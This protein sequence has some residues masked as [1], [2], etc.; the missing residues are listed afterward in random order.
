V[1]ARSRQAAQLAYFLEQRAG[2]HRVE[3]VWMGAGTDRAY[4]G[5]Q[6]QWIDGP[7]PQEMRG[8]VAQLADQA[9][10]LGTADLRY[11]RGRTD[12]AEAAALL[13]Y[14]DD[15]PDEAMDAN[16][17]TVDAAFTATSYPE[18]SLD[19]WPQRARALLS[20]SQHASL[21]TGD[22]LPAL[23][24]RI[25]ADGWNG[26]I[27]WLDAIAASADDP[28]EAGRIEE[29]GRTSLLAGTDE[30]PGRFG[31]LVLAVRSCMRRIRR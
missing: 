19:P 14:L 2:L 10:A 20:L 31:R 17:F 3:C 29:E 9:P 15:H 6:L 13:R 4:S 16:T 12:L 5:W 1:S 22:A 28:A 21:H 25:R 8:L 11:S 7:T 24:R 30:H 23:I 26:A 27:A 18:S